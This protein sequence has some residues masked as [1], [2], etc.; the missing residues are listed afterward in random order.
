MYQWTTTQHTYEGFPLFLRRPIDVDTP[1]HRSAFPILAI[2]THEFRKR[3]PDGRPDLVYNDSLADFDHA[4][5]TAFD[6]A[7]EGVPVLVETFGGKRHYYFY[8]APQ[9]NVAAMVSRI[10]EG[11]LD[12]LIAGETR[13][14]ASWNFLDR[15]ARQYFPHAAASLGQPNPATPSARRTIS[16]TG[17]S[18]FKILTL[19]FALL[20]GLLLIG[21]SFDAGHIR[22]DI[23]VPMGVVLGLFLWF[24][25][26]RKTVQM[27]DQA[28]YVSVFRRVTT[29]PLTQISEVTESRGAKD[30]SVTVHF[31]DAT[32][33][34]RSITFSP[35]L[36]LSRE[37][38]PIVAELLHMRK[39]RN[40]Q[41][42]EM[43]DHPRGTHF[44]KIANGVSH[45]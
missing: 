12:E 31:C 5:V 7:Q 21:A 19:F 9:A 37:P 39:S 32:P 40:R 13:A 24:T 6:A 26:S 3:L 23:A 18:L 28:L 20:L 14:D 10:E 35:S 33:L 45:P 22:W 11:F 30:R 27:D 29:I 38:H 1:A 42:A 2:I 16:S 17:S 44:C 34:G 8:V 15:Y 41:A 25:F 43:S 4:I 36:L